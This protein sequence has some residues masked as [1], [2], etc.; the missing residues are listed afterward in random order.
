M[1]KLDLARTKI[2]QLDLEIIRLFEE[3]MTV[4]KEV[5]EYKKANNIP[6]LDTNREI[7][8]FLRQ[9]LRGRSFQSCIGDRQT[10][11]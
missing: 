2:D 7:A 5:I 8:M 1:S 4:V 11:D 6:V 3:R 9:T 10:R